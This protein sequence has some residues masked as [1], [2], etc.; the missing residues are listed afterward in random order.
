VI[1]ATRDRQGVDDAAEIWA[2]A[3]AA[4]DGD[5]EV[6]ELDVSRPIIQRVLDRSPRAFVLLARS[7]SGVAAGFAAIEPLNGASETVAEVTYF[8]VRP[9]LWGRGIGT[10]LLA[11]L[12]HRLPRA[13]FAS[14]KLSVYVANSRAI[15]MYERMGWRPLGMPTPHPRT[16]KPEQR[17]EWPTAGDASAQTG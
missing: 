3:T 9:D 2:Q 10:L 13:G 6:A 15:E 14:I 16:G 7:H 12:Q 1:E 11:D 5:Q 17:Y 4:R 8:G